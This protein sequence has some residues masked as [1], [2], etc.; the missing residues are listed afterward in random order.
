[1]AETDT[2]DSGRNQ[3]LEDRV[4]WTKLR[5]YVCSLQPM[6]TALTYTRI[7]LSDVRLD[8]DLDVVDSASRHFALMLPSCCFCILQMSYLALAKGGH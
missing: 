6:L 3:A 5:W 1:M 8:R 7:N 2:L 4:E